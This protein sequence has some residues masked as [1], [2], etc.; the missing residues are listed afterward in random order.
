MKSTL[1]I[2]VLSCL[3]I[4]SLQNSFQCNVSGCQYCSFPNS[5]GL[6][7]NNNV[8]QFNTTSGAFYCQSVTCPANCATCYQNNVCQ[9]CASGFFITSSGACSNSASGSSSLPPNCL[10]GNNS[11]NCGICSY[12]FSL[13]NGYCY[14]T[15]TKSVNDAYCTIKLTSEIC[16]ICQSGYFVNPI[17]RCVQNTLN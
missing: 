12:G 4:L 5:C 13:Q 10:W 3:V 6:C 16:Q 2:L 1:A 9:T 15:I 17:G 8:L 11:T 7:Q 14:P